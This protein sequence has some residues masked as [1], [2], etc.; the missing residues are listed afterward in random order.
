MAVL[1]SRDLGFDFRYVHFDGDWIIYQICFLWK[2]EPILREQILKKYKDLYEMPENYE[3]PEGAFLANDLR[4]DWFLLILGDVLDTD[5]AEFWQPLEPDI[6]VALYSDNFFPFVPEIIERKGQQ[7]QYLEDMKEAR[8]K[9]KEE[10]GKQPDDPFQLIIFAN[11]K[12]LKD[13]VGY[14]SEGVGLKMGVK[15][16]QLEN[17]YDELEVEYAEFKRAFKIDE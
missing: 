2:N 11:T 14:T 12:I 6:T 9:L 16:Q 3:L 15:R 17:F 8:K 10:K 5:K 4:E 1:R 13:E 7:L